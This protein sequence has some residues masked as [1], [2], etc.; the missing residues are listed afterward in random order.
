V[1]RHVW[2]L[3]QAF[4]PRALNPKPRQTL[5]SLG[6]RRICIWAT[7]A[8]VKTDQKPEI[9]SK[10]RPA[11]LGFEV[12]GSEIPNSGKQQTARRR[13][14]SWTRHAP[15]PSSSCF[16]SSCVSLPYACKRL[17]FRV[18][19]S[20][21]GTNYTSSCSCRSC[22]GLPYDCERSQGVTICGGRFPIQ[23]IL[24]VV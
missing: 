24:H 14:G 5:N 21:F 13:R 3:P 18:R 19:G 8:Y 7:G 16:C 17:G 23:D 22:V 11:R 6:H 4:I 12:S 15:N 2:T 9:D 10:R 1:C 20:R